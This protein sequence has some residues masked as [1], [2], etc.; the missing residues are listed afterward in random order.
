MMEKNLLVLQYGM[1]E[2]RKKKATTT[3]NPRMNTSSTIQSI[4]QAKYCISN[5]LIII[6]EIIHK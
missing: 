2:K 4:F 5:M 1:V 6:I 3:R